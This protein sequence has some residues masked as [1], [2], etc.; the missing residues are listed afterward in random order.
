[1]N[2]TSRRILAVFLA[3]LL[4]SLPVLGG[5]R[6][7]ANVSAQDG[8]ESDGLVKIEGLNQEPQAE[9]DDASVQ[10][11]YLVGDSPCDFNNIESVLADTQFSNGDKILLQGGKTFK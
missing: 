9:S 1:M 10:F 3:I 8:V 11:T 4:T 7:Q 6:P 2:T 5:S